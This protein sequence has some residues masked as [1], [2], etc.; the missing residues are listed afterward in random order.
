MIKSRWSLSIVKT[1]KGKTGKKPLPNELPTDIHKPELA[2][3]SEDRGSVVPELA[4]ITAKELQ[5]DEQRPVHE[6]AG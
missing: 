4:A 1:E 5:G 2:D 6:L 3:S